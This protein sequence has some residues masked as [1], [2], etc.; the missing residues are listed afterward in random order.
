MQWPWQ[1]K[2]KESDRQ[3]KDRLV[4]RARGSRAAASLEASDEQWRTTAV[5]ELPPESA[6]NIYDGDNLTIY[7]RRWGRAVGFGARPVPK[8]RAVQEPEYFGYELTLHENR[9]YEKQTLL[10]Q[11]RRRLDPLG[12]AQ[13]GVLAALNWIFGVKPKIL[14]IERYVWTECFGHFLLGSLGFTV[15][16]IITSIFSLGEKIFSK[17]IPPF[18]IAR[19]LLLSA[20]AFLVLAIPVAVVFATLMGMSRLNR[21]NELVAFTTNGI[22]LY[23]I[24]VPFVSLGIFAGIM[25]WLIYEHVVPPNNTQYKDVLKVFWESQVVDFIKPG[26]VIKAPEKKYFYVEEINKTEG[27]MYDLRLYDYFAGS[28]TAPPRTYPR[29]FAAKRAWVKDK[30][31]VLSD[32]QLYELDENKGD[33]LVCATM[34]EIKIDISTRTKEYSI[35]PHPTELTAEQLRNRIHRTR[36]TLSS[37]M[38]PS[39]HL[40]Q[41]LLQDWTEYYFK[42][43]IPFACLAFV[44]VA[45]PVSLRG[46]RDERNLGLIMT[47]VLVMAYYILF[48]VARLLGSR[49]VIPVEDISVFGLTLIHK[50]ANLFP[51]PLAGWLAA[52]V[53]IAASGF[54]IYSARK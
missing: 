13:R 6:E 5:E 39:P 40:K 19:V 37:M 44:L 18:T 9:K 45:V 51:P 16:M 12:A 31:L 4:K 46:P 3:V 2:R 36:D 50:G 22:S 48:F 42:Y 33:N 15:F 49:G 54:M 43:S 11:K 29:I 24:F 27:V 30:F 20:P 23:R 26:I 21:D 8:Q 32:V 52:G 7:V 34:P 35:T 41:R 53:F 47:F 10:T 28:E 38:Y 25:T 14:I 17:D 1:R